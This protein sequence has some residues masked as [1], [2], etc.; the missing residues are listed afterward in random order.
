VITISNKEMKK[1]LKINNKRAQITIFIILALAI[2]VLL[3]LLFTRNNELTTIFNT[4]SPINQI[5]DCSKEALSEGL[6]LISSQ[7]GSISPENYYLYENNKIEYLCYT[8]E[9]YKEGIIQKPLLKQSIEKELKK[10]ITPKIK[11]CIDSVKTSLEKKSYI[12]S[13]KDPEISLELIPNNIFATIDL[14]LKITK[15]KTESYK[16]IKT[17]IDSNLYKIIM[18]ASSILNFE[19]SQG[20]SEIM[21]YMIYYPSLKIEKKIQGDGTKIYIL[22]DKTSLEKF[23][24]AS[25]SLVFPPGIIGK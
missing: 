15:D 19:A 20:D 11:G 10:Y 17:N 13:Y 8:E 7:G 6:E 21:T 25:K 22:T 1:R 14:D 5:K 16:S 2:I 4:K 18:I 23:M 12:V 3:V 9:N 24:F